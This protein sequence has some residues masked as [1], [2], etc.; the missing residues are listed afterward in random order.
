[1]EGFGE[2]SYENLTKKHRA[3]KNDNASEAES[4]VLG[5][6]TS[7]SGERKGD[8]PCAWE[9]DPENGSS[10]CNRRRVKRDIRVWEDVI[11]DS[12]C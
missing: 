4:T 7:E 11:A 2:K 10:G 12:I 9:Q 8:L 1:M 6:R 5:F 3:G